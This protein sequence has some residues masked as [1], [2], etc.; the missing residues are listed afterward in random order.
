M[1][2]RTKFKIEAVFETDIGVSNIET[3]EK[4]TLTLGKKVNKSELVIGT[5]Y[6]GLVNA[7]YLNF[8][9]RNTNKE[10]KKVE[11]RKEEKV[12]IPKAPEVPKS[13][14]NDKSDDILAQSTL[15][16]ATEIVIA[17]YGQ[18]TSLENIKGMHRDIFNY[19]KNKEYLLDKNVALAQ[20]VLIEAGLKKDT[21]DEI[22]II[23]LED[24]DI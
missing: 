20:K 21:S 2:E 19:M 8:V 3:G 22:P 6:E 16:I 1:G 5:V 18:K 10:E 17:V 4:Y 9:F 11:Q 7:N 12:V 24:D 23:D 15:K 14:W 13:V